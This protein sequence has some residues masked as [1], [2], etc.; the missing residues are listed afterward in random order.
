MQR[1]FI[2]K[3]I[4]FELYCTDKKTIEKISEELNVDRRVIL[5]NLKENGI[6]LRE[7]RKEKI[8]KELLI[9]LY[10]NKKLSMREIA[11]ILGVADTFV[12]YSLYEHD[13]PRRNKSWK[14]SYTK[15]GEIVFCEICKKEIYRKRYTL[16]KYSV[17]FCSWKCEK[18]YQSITRS[19]SE[20][21]ESW[22]RK[23][24]YR[25]W[26]R[27]VLKRDNYSCKLCCSKNKLVSHHILEAKEFPEKRY[28]LN[29][30]IT[31]CKTCHIKVHKEDS[32]T[33]IKSLQEAI[34]V[35]NP[36]IGEN[37]HVDN[38]EGR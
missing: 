5:R 18:E 36:N 20:L 32:H 8:S 21:G 3:E 23:S 38:P 30:G 34:F 11:K 35:E 6:E 9:D 17:F 27:D 16:K 7:N 37:P 15:T 19:I 14:S 25:K 29:N 22:R 12:R 28:D 1:I 13:I 2:K 10:I 33:Y 26:R 31:L 24:H 4:L